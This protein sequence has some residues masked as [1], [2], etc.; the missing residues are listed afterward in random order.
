ME[1]ARHAAAMHDFIAAQAPALEA[2]VAGTGCANLEEQ[3]AAIA[4]VEQATAAAQG[5]FDA[6]E[7]ATAQANEAVIVTN[8]HSAHTVERLRGALGQLRA[9]TKQYATEIRNQIL[10]R[11]SRGITP[12]QMREYRDSF[13]FFDK[14]RAARARASGGG[15]FVDVVALQKAV[16]GAW[17]YVSRANRPWVSFAGRLQGARPGRVPRLPDLRR[18]RYSA[19]GQGMCV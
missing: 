17:V 2:A 15:C 12:E 9:A 10:T 3:L 8:S 18:L 19:A 5:L 6:V 4:A 13:A 1:W 16:R 14:V 11:D 7:A